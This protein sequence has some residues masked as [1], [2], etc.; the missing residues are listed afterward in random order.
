MQRIGTVLWVVVLAL[1][2]SGCVGCGTYNDLVA[3][4]ESVDQAWADVEAQYQRRA[5]LIPN[6]VNTVKGAANFEQETLEAVTQARAQ[7]TSI[8]LSVEDLSDPAMVRQYQEAQAQLSG[9][10]GRLLAVA[11]DYPQLQA[12]E[13]FRDLQAQLEGTEN[14]INVARMR[15]NEAV[16]AYNTQVRQFPGL[17]VANITGFERREP[18]E[19]DPGAEEPPTVDFDS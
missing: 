7:A 15:Y 5:D 13:A 3:A 18:F 1:A 2:T 16:R 12:T 9:A 10:L 4:E 14:R 8:N 17:I 19:A 6:L 11:E